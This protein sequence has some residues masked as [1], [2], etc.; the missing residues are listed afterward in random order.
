MC[1]Q[2]LQP[3]QLFPETT[4]LNNHAFS[5]LPRFSRFPRDYPIE[6]PCV[7]ELFQLF[8]FFPGTTALNNL[9]F[10]AFPACS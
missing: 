1:F 3:F 6:P 10:P 9:W 8:Q 2:L 4:A 5:S 7:L